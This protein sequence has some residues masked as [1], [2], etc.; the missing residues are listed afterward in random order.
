VTTVVPNAIALGVGVVDMSGSNTPTFP[1][2]NAQTSGY[3]GGVYVG[4]DATSPMLNGTWA[5]ICAKNLAVTTSFTFFV[6]CGLEMQVSPSSTLAPQLK[7]SPPYDPVALTTYFQIAREL[8]DGYPSEFNDLGKI[9]DVI[10]KAARKIIPFVG[11]IP[12]AKTGAAV[13]NTIVTAGD[14]IRANR[15]AKKESKKAAEP[16]KNKA[17][18]KRK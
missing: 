17:P 2:V 13:A 9:W 15:Q 6:R 3:L 11:M 16:A 4:G 5:H 8:K 14:Q 12:G 10:S 18:A 1:H 7:L